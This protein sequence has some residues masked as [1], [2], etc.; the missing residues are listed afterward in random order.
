MI[1]LIGDLSSGIR[2]TTQHALGIYDQRDFN[3]IH[4]TTAGWVLVSDHLSIESAA[5]A[6][7]A[8]MITEVDQ[9]IKHL[10]NARKVI[11]ETKDRIILEH[12]GQL[13][14]DLDI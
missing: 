6:L 14:L 13:S 10:K 4:N 3:K 2:E 5:N 12:S 7:T 8:F 9:R 11:T 1:C